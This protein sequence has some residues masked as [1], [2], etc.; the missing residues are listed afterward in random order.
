MSDPGQVEHLEQ[1]T[2]PE[3]QPTPMP[4]AP[5]LQGREGRKAFLLEQLEKAEG[6]AKE[7]KEQKEPGPARAANGQFAPKQAQDDKESQAPA[8][9]PKP[10]DAAPSQWKK[11]KAAL[12]A[13]MAPEA[14]EY[15]YQREQQNQTGVQPLLQK[16][17]F[18]DQ[19]N[20]VA[21]PYLEHI[22]G[23][24]L[25]LPAAVGG[26]MRV[27]HQLRTLPYQQKLAVLQS[28]MAGYG[29]N[30]GALIQGQS[31]QQAPQQFGSTGQPAY[32]MPPEILSIQ[33]ELT[34]IKGQTATNA[35][36]QKA[37]LDYEAGLQ[38]QKFAEKAEHFE[39]VRPVMKQL[40]EAGM[41]DGL[42]DAYDK[43]IR[44]NPDLFA[45]IDAAQKAEAEKANRKAADEAAKRAKAAAVSPRSGTPGATSAANA[46]QD[47]R[48]MLREAF[49]NLSERL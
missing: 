25:D 12:W 33:N 18:A 9:E 41:A 32:A 22:R 16:A 29:I 48:S 37:Q 39:E 4:Q 2:P 44:L 21:E 31:G 49:D 17:A 46:K 1:Q 23:L 13:A 38:I 35:E 42:Q 19:I 36:Q 45:K 34:A 26:M 11:D 28:I 27:D 14:R 30:L 5:A 15:V 20:K 40:I 10:W 3:P 43:A 6:A 24:G 7:H 8:P 47:R